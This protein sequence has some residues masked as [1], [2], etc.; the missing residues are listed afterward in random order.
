MTWT[1]TA[2]TGAEFVAELADRFDEG[3]RFDV[4]DRAADLAK[5]EI[6]P[7]GIVDR[8]SLDRVGDVRNDLDGR[9]EIVAA[10]FAGDDVR[11][12]AAAGDIVRWLSTA[13]R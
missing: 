8:E 2:L 11:I 1:N 3:E 6:Q 10:P 12:D 4:A 5:H 9:T 7:V 13:R